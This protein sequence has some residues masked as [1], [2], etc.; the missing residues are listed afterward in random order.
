MSLPSP[1]AF[2]ALLQI[3]AVRK[4]PGAL[5]PLSFSPV[6]AQ[7]LDREEHS[8]SQTPGGPS[9]TQGLLFPQVPS[10]SRE[11][12]SLPGSRENGRSEESAWSAAPKLLFTKGRKF[13]VLRF[14]WGN[15]ALF[16]VPVQGFYS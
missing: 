9:P 15:F 16:S 2:R 4:K 13:G 3:R 11:A 1:T 7:S 6:L 14:F 5:S 8:V 12:L 10:V